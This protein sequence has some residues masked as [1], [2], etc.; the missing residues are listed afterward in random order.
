MYC[1]G[2]GTQLQDTA[3]YC[4]ECGRQTG[5]TSSA[6]YQAP[7]RLYRLAYD[8]KW[9]GVCAGLARYLD[10]DVTLIRIAV[11]AA[12]FCTGGMVLLAYIVASIIMPVD[13]GLPVR[14]SEVHATS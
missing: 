13:Y 12:F 3:N 7:R 8:K 4:S 11:V 10:V 5:R 2:C 14:A 6:Q 1:T 9:A